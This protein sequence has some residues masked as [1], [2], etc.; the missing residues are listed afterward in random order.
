MFRMDSF[1]FYLK[2]INIGRLMISN[3]LLATLENNCY[4]LMVFGKFKLGESFYY[5]QRLF[6]QSRTITKYLKTTTTNNELSNEV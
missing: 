4:L 3:F 5:W 2:W 1:R 6:Q